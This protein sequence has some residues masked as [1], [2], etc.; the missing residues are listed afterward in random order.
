MLFFFLLVILGP[1]IQQSLVAEGATCSE[2]FLPL[3]FVANGFK[4]VGG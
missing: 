2:V 3:F 1:K 4:G